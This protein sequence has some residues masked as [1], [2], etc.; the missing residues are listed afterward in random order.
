MKFHPSFYR[1]LFEVVGR[2][3]KIL[4]GPKTASVELDTFHS[5]LANSENCHALLVNY[6]YDNRKKKLG[7]V[8]IS[9]RVNILIIVPTVI[10]TGSKSSNTVTIIIINF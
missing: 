1:Y 4:H 5:R 9:I 3:M 10:H 2:T 7:V 8:P 6:S